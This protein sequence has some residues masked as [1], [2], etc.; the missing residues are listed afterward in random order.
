MVV[1]A[2][3]EE[4]WPT[5]LTLAR[6]HAQ[7]LPSFG[8]H[9]WYIHERS[10][11][12]KGKLIRYLDQVPSAVGEIGLDRWKPEL[13]YEGQEE[14]FLTQLRVAAERDLPVSIHC[15]RAWGRLLELLRDG[16]RPHRGF[17]LHSYGGPKEMIAPLARLGAYFSF[18]GYFLHERK[19]R[20][21]ETFRHV[22]PDRLMIE[23]DAPDRLPPENFNPHPLTDS[24]G[25][26]IHHPANLAAIYDGLARILGESVASLA[27][28]VEQNFSRLFGGL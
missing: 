4:D 27:I 26:A 17:L 2:S 25:N 22:P 18:P 13:A 16:P 20:Q 8:Y 7:V 23:T 11:A 15:L 5:V 14:V 10:P 21:R 1:N 3:S 28:R 9:P 24:K 6:A 12:W 19:N